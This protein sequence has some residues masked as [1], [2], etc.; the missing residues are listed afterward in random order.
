MKSNLF[1]SLSALVLSCL[2]DACALTPDPM[3][4]DDCDGEG[5]AGATAGN[6]GSGGEGAQGAS[7]PDNDHDNDGFDAGDGPDEDCDD[8][9][10]D[11]NPDAAEICGDGVDNNCD[12][13]IDEGCE[14]DPGETVACYSGPSSTREVGKCRDGDMTCSSHSA[15]GTCVGDVTPVDED[16]DDGV[17]NDCDG[18]IDGADSQCDTGGEYS[19]DNV[20]CTDGTVTYTITASAILAGALTASGGT[21][22]YNDQRPDVEAVGP[23]ADIPP[24]SGYSSPTTWTFKG[25]ADKSF[26]FN[27]EGEAADPNAPNNVAY[28]CTLYPINGLSPSV[29]V[30]RDGV[31]ISYQ[32]NLVNGAPAGDGRNCQMNGH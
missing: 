17:D 21:V 16:C 10:A 11:V 18:D 19:W 23:W 32:D 4:C 25:C 22:E 30:K 28:T 31:V 6:G 20:L 7:A 1:V 14:C 9:D 2:L 27:V 3:Q 13:V 15:W 8:D 29:V 12:G 24:G 26:R 5:G